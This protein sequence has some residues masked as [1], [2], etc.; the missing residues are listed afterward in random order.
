[1]QTVLRAL[2]LLLGYLPLAV[3]H[4]LGAALGR[5]LWWLPNGLRRIT[6]LHLARC[7]PELDDA[8]RSRIARASL[9]ESAKA[10]LEAPAIWYGP[11]ARRR[12]WLA[13]PA[14]LA[15]ICAAQKQGKGVILLTPHQ[16]AWELA[17]FFCAQA[18]PITVLFK[19]Q[20]GAAD[21]L[22]RAGRGRGAPVTPVPTTGAG[23]KALLAALKR[24][25]L[26]GILP[27]HDPPESS[28]TA[29]VPMF[30]IPANTMDLVTKLAARS[31]ASVLLIVAE[32]LP[33]ARGFRFHL[34][35]APA[36]I[37]DAA[38][39]PAVMNAAVETC[40]R[41]FPEQYWWSYK[42]YRRRPPGEPDFYRSL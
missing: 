36:D 3:L 4:L 20:K 41:A 42:R 35:P 11:L 12:R 25:E 28:G 18:A 19:P 10:V 40:V 13:A 27:D 8:A 17:S 9:I 38:T 37:A 34:W 1:M 5:L 32:R 39:G 24:G 6:E 22:I 33:A 2:F 30:G 7:L 16:G 31:G 26:V 15:T 23:V 21:A 14:A 29:F